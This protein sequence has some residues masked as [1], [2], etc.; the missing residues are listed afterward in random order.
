MN[1]FLDIHQTSATDLRSIIDD[2]AAMKK[3][4]AGRPRGA[5]D[6]DQPLKDHMVL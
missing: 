4:R 1:H 6:D 3:S 5:P 2:A